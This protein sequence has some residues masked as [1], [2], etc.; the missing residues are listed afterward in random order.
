[1]SAARKALV[2]TALACALSL[3]LA[4][5]VSPSPERP[6]D[7]KEAARANA[8]LGFAYLQQGNLSLAKDKLERAE[9]QDDRN[10]DVQ[11]A[12]GLLYERMNRKADA[13]RHYAAARRLAPESGEIANTYAVFLCNNGK[14]EAGVKEFEAA[15]K[16]PL[17]PT[18]W[19]ALANAGVCLRSAKRNAD[20]APYLQQAIQLRPNF[21]AAV[22]ELADL[23]LA[24][25]KAQDAND[26]V[27]RY[28]SMGIAS[29][30]VLL[31]GVRAAQARG[32]ANG[33]AA[34]AR[35]LRRDFPQSE[36]ARALPQFLKEKG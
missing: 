27:N 5:C 30:D 13:E 31:V 1:V 10:P 15:A 25:G 9:R 6:K 2:S 28:L 22:T 3:L 16:N 23:Q 19:A 11:S 14:A 35:R 21:A 26:T 20:A 8:Q 18:P 17:Y 24:E 29:P 33:A 34:L 4:A 12:L 36:Q 32:D 7:S